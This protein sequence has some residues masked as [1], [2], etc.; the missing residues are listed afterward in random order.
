MRLFGRE[1]EGAVL[2][3]LVA[4]RR[5]RRSAA[6]VLRGE[7]GVG[8]T[9][10]LRRAQRADGRALWVSGVEAEA[11]FPYAALH[12]LL[13]PMLGG[14]DRLPE[15]QRVALEVAC[16]LSD[17]APADLYLVSLATLTLLAREPR[18]CIVDDAQWVDSESLRALAFVGRR[19]HAEGVVL[20]FGLRAEPGDADPLPGLPVRRIGG[21]EP[22]AAVALLGEVVDG[23]VNP[24]LAARIVAVT[25]GNP[26][27]LTDLGREL[28]AD[29][30]DGTTPLPEPMPIGSRPESH[31]SQRIA[32]YPAATRTW[33]LLAAANAG[34]DGALVAAAASQ[35]GADAA[36]AEADRFVTGSPPVN[37]RHPLVLSAV[38]GAAS[39]AERRAAHRALAAA[40]TDPG[41]A[42]R[43]AWHRAAAA[44]GPD[45]TVA[46]DL[47]RCAERAGARGGHTARAGF[48][49]R[50][51]E[52][53]PDPALRARRRVRAAGA[54]MAAG[55]PARALAL[56]D[57]VDERTL[58]G[59]ARGAALMTRAYAEVDAGVPEGLLHAPA[60]CL[61]AA[62]AFGD[63]RARAREAV[64]QAI[65][66]VTT[67]EHLAGVAEARIAAVAAPLAGDDDLDGLLLAGYAAFTVGGY[68][69]GVPALR[70][71]VTAITDP[72]RPE[73]QLLNRLVVG[74]NFC[75][76]LW[77]DESRR[78]ILDR[79]EQVARRTGALHRLDLV[80]FLG[81]TTAAM[82]GRLDEA[83]RHDT[84]GQRLRQA[85]GLTAAQEPVWQHPELLAWRGPAEARESIRPTLDVF[86]ALHLGGLHGTTRLSLA[87]LDIAAGDY[88]SARD[89]LRGLVE[90]G[91]PR[92]YAW[93][94]PD[95]VEAALR[96]GD[97]KTA[98]QAYSDLS[99]AVVASGMPRVM[100]LLER[101][102]ALLS[103]AEDAERH[104][105][106]A[107]IQLSG[108]IAHGDL[109]RAHLLY[110]EWLRRRRRRRDANYHLTLAL[111]MFDE[112]RAGAFAERA[113]QEL[114]ALGGTVLTPVQPEDETALTPQEA[115]VARLARNGG[116][117]AEIAAHMFLSTNTVD[118]HLRKVY[119]KLGVSSRRQ[120]RETLHD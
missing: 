43:R 81:A 90:L 84:A 79:A 2:D 98:E 62:E 63:D 28:T 15:R 93:A 118:Y 49:G 60:K 17:G 3:R 44:D 82:L 40:V 59:A 21:L 57:A 67:A 52:L 39:A 104:Y 74:V 103:G 33:L 6:L 120:L 45:E 77:D 115:A 26:L 24:A 71:A 8:K 105:Q 85:I 58:P 35:L 20:L 53:T 50:A 70:R 80:H 61:A 64:L 111:E 25:G 5:E 114:R 23:A 31:Y 97:R 38:Y 69:S 22:E 4:G 107:I 94:L 108:T 13:V 66:H 96:A 75:H 68:E 46:A 14:R 29:H 7:A 78:T 36:A 32:A 34:G 87:V 10:L 11:D 76:L 65:E 55:A 95:L 47:E 83:D 54:A 109:A 1:A 48:L 106:Q 101:C 19:L 99:L 51:A 116:T 91:R 88:A 56:L 42:D 110:G 16:G 102:C 119:R 100:G 30:W 72:R 9:S 113:R 92:R 12:R 89:T 37:F 27:A 18:L 117:N 112:V 41:E 73:E 86:A